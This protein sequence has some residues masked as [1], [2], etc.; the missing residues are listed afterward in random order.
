M[1]KLM[2]SYFGKLTATTLL[3]TS[4]STSRDAKHDHKYHLD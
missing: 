3:N 1:K 2:L 4:I